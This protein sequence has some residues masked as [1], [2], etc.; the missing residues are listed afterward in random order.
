M[1]ITE[2][3]SLKETDIKAAGTEMVKQFQNYQSK[4]LRSVNCIKM[5]T[6]L[7]SS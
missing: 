4:S 6:N 2:N 7:N 5:K 3:I 1:T